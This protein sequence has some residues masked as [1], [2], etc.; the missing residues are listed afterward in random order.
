MANPT[1]RDLIEHA[2]KRCVDVVG[3][4]M[5]LTDTAEQEAVLVLT[6]AISLLSSSASLLDRVLPGFKDRDEI[7]RA[8][9]LA[10]AAMVIMS[11]PGHRARREDLTPDITK[12][13]LAIH[14]MIAREIPEGFDRRER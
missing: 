10:G 1:S 7:Q 3:Q 6:V 8:G 12:M 11:P 9:I 4:A 5:Q 13:I 14:R 2:M